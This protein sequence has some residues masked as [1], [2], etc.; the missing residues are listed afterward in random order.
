MKLKYLIK[1]VVIGVSLLSGD[2]IG[3]LKELL[4]PTD[5]V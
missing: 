1:G 5:A 3:A 4:D 2:P